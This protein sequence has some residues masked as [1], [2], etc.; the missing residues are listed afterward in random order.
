[1]RVVKDLTFVLTDEQ[2]AA[3]QAAVLGNPQEPNEA[4]KALLSHTA[5]DRGLVQ[6]GEHSSDMVEWVA[7]AMFEAHELRRSAFPHYLPARRFE[8]DR[9]VWMPRARDALNACHH[10]ELVEALQ[11]ARATLAAISSLAMLDSDI[12]NGAQGEAKRIDAL[13]NKLGGDA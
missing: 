3:F 10:A 7:R 8:D 4:L 12:G 2:F 9:Q 5:D 6:S 1:M 11:Q 13:L